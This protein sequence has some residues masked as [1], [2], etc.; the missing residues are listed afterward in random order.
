[1]R[2]LEVGSSGQLRSKDFTESFPPY[3]ILSHTWGADDS[4]VT[5]DDLKNGSGTNKAGYAKIQFCGEQARKDN[6]QYVWVDTCC[7]DKTNLVELQEAINSMFRW[8]RDAG[9]CYVYLQTYRSATAMT[10][11]RSG[12]GNRTFEKADGSNGAGRF[13]NLLRRCQWSSSHEKGSTWA[14]KP[15][16]NSRSTR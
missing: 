15:H 8:Y 16:S 2:L 14:V 3:A 1:M 11:I 12:H 9:K 13:K 7:I 5:F 4:E 10:T 6:L